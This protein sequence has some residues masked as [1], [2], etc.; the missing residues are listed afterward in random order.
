[1]DVAVD[2]LLAAK[3]ASQAPP[4]TKAYWLILMWMAIAAAAR[5]MPRILFRIWRG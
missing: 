4:R 3:D 1:M 2:S 5:F